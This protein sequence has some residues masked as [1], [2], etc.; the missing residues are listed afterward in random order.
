MYII[1]EDYIRRILYGVQSVV[2]TLRLQ[3]RGE[4]LDLVQAI[5]NLLECC[6]D[7]DNK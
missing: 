4:T 7:I 1:K 5:R 3:E 2:R 6:L